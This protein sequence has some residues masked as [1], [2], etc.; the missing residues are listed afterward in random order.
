M[1]LTAK[2][3]AATAIALGMS[4]QPLLAQTT[5]TSDLPMEQSQGEVRFRTGGIGLDES[6]AFKSAIPRH[7]ATLVFTSHTGG[8]NEYLADVPVTVT[9]SRGRQVLQA[10]V[11]PYLLLDLPA[12]NYVATARYQDQVLTRKFSVG[13]RKGNRVAFDWRR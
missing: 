4:T 6:T 10:S 11:G 12:G 1:G 3:L 9:D 13:T 5:S 7:S 8:N 2:F